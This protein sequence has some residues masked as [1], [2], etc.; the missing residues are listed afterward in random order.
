[1]KEVKERNRA[2]RTSAVPT[3]DIHG[4]L[5]M[6]LSKRG[7]VLWL[8]NV[9]RPTSTNERFGA[10]GIRG[11]ENLIAKLNTIFKKKCALP[12]I[13]QESKLLRSVFRET[14]TVMEVVVDVVRN[15]LTVTVR[16]QEANRIVGAVFEQNAEVT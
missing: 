10:H 5:D 13:V 6:D 7:V 14:A 8:R 16:S 3:K 15:G 1:M 2:P 9:E 11:E 12:M 4:A